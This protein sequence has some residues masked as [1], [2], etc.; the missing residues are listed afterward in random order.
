MAA[1]L[2]INGRIWLKSQ[3]C[4]KQDLMT[5]EILLSSDKSD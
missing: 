2:D 1:A 5:D 4:T 3:G